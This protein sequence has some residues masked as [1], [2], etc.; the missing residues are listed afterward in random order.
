M[1]LMKQET[2][3]IIKLYRIKSGL[4]QDQLVDKIDMSKAFL[5]EIERGLKMPSLLTIFRISNAL[6]IEAW[7]IVKD[8]EEEISN[9]S[10]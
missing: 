1:I 10:K 2:G 4:S 7:K 6:D 3:K 5:S 8:I 9:T